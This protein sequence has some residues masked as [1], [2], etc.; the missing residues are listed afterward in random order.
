MSYTLKKYQKK[1]VIS[2]GNRI[3]ESAIVETLAAYALNPTS[4]DLKDKA[5]R[6]HGVQIK[7]PTGSG[8]TIII[9]S[10][11]KEHLK[12][13]VVLVFSPGAG[14]LEEQTA[15]K[16]NVITGNTQ[17]ITESTFSFAPSPGVNYVSNWEALV[18]MRK[19]SNAYLTK[20]SKESENSNIF[21]WLGKLSASKTPVAIIVDESHHG[22]AK[23]SGAI[24]SFLDDIQRTLG[25][26]P[27]LI[28]A[29][30]TPILKDRA[31]DG[32][33]SIEVSDV[34]KAGLLRKSV[35]LNSGASEIIQKMTV[36]QRADTDLEEVIF[37][38]AYKKLKEID[39]EYVRV[40]S[41]YHGLMAIQLPSSVSGKEAIDR[42]KAF[43]RP[44]GITTEN[45][46]MA[47]FMN[48]A[49]EGDM[50]IIHTPESPVRVLLY[51]QGISMGWD[52][53]R[54]QVLVGLRHL[55]SKTFTT[56]NLGRFI[57]TTEAKHYENDILDF[58]YVYSN[59]GDM[60]SKNY[61][62]D[63][64]HTLQYEGEVHLRKD[65]NG[66]YALQSINDLNLELVVFRNK[67]QNA[68]DR[69]NLQKIWLKKVNESRLWERIVDVDTR[70]VTE[71]VGEGEIAVSDALVDGDDAIDM[72]LSKGVGINHM[73]RWNELS[74]NIQAV[75]T[76][77]DRDFGNNENVV[78]ITLPAIIRWF[79]EA[80]TK[81]KSDIIGRE[82]WGTKSDIYETVFH[83]LSTKEKE[84]F[85]LNAFIT[86]LLLDNVN[87]NHLRAVLS[88]VF[89]DVSIAPVVDVA[90]DGEDITLKGTRLKE[91][92]DDAYV[93]P[94]TLQINQEE[95]H[96]ID[97]PNVKNYAYVQEHFHGDNTS[98]LRSFRQEGK[99][100]NPEKQFETFLVDTAFFANKDVMYMKNGLK[101]KVNYSTAVSGK[102][103]E[104]NFHPDYLLEFSK[105]TNSVTSFIPAIFEVKDINI[106]RD[107][108]RMVLDKAQFLIDL[109]TS[110]S[111]PAGIV[112]PDGNGGFNVITEVNARGGIKTENL[113]DF[114]INSTKGW[115]TFK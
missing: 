93:L 87:F 97:L 48:G 106:S 81:P 33:M 38:A 39:K 28:E 4:K 26:A 37:E 56:Q 86:E 95:K 25:Y 96:E 64:D 110:K 19:G 66:R 31:E 75:V 32:T 34:I 49:K 91:V 104:S 44:Y 76:S 89:S 62:K 18:S 77:D 13:F 84:K 74:G 36:A 101:Q 108:D 92:L 41:D 71:T 22:S 80:M 82:H 45:G 16:L 107:I 99:L 52:C 111:I 58:A 103:K 29:S 15:K 24:K 14:N 78:R 70:E 17:I 9:G 51:K 90:V 69:K 98:S 63:A 68:L 60:G 55:T 85:D 59:V 109:S 20:L 1:V 79:T 2:A 5:N 113:V 100:Y 21:D 40:N 88:E 83:N 35:R 112:F 54:A 7:A 57:R 72:K 105:K 6:F 23:A 30:A 46:Q 12:N 27:Y 43:F 8:K 10:L 102:D 61:E 114:V 3:N 47:L 50:D 11:I 115:K 53:P 67:K 94:R 73:V 65:N 42:I